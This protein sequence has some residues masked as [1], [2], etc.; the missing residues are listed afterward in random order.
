MFVKLAI[1]GTK[2][3]KNV[4]EI[5]R[6][7]IRVSVRMEMVAADVAISMFILNPSVKF[8]FS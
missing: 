1:I 3:G 8:H 2:Q 6:L 7:S 5:V 4:I